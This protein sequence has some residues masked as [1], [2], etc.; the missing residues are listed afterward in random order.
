MEPV[1]SGAK[2]IDAEPVELWIVRRRDFVAAGVLQFSAIEGV[3]NFRFFAEGVS[4]RSVFGT[5]ARALGFTR[6]R[7]LKLLCG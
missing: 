4:E 3:P 7:L 1:L 6:G 5:R 2:V